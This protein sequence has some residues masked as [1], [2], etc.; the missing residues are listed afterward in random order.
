ML[1]ED[2]RPDGCCLDSVQSRAPTYATTSALAKEPG[3]TERMAH[4]HLAHQSDA[5]LFAY[6]DP[7]VQYDSVSP[8]CSYWPSDLEKECYDRCI[9]HGLGSC[10]RWQT[11][12]RDMIRNR[13]VMAHKLS[14]APCCTPST[15]VLSPRHSSSSRSHQDGQHDSGSVYK[16]P[17]RCELAT[18]AAA[19][20]RPPS[21]GR[22]T[23]PLHPG[24]TCSRTPAQA[25]YCRGAGVIHGE[26]RLHPLTVK[27]IG[28]YSAGRRWIS[29]HQRRTLTARYFI[30]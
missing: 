13:E 27:I 25:P 26:W 23:P 1:S 17:R 29:S 14:G 21:V 11:S 15:R 12:L 16:S 10:M 24:S 18:T 30:H 8:G 5:R 22:S 20:E 6:A 19:G 3:A 4:G 28:V 2:A 9:E 7:L